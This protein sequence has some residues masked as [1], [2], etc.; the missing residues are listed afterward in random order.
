MG[1]VD[2]QKS[3]GW[4][5]KMAQSWQHH[6]FATL[7]HRVMWF[8]SKCT[9][10]NCLHDSKGQCLN[11]AVEY[12][13]ARSELFQSNVNLY[14]FIFWCKFVIKKVCAKSNFSDW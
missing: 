12:S 5:I 4:S 11:T 6:N 2:W 9:E 10:R 3:T 1:P 13:A 8:L 14:T 7:C